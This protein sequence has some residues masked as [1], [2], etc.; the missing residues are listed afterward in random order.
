MV[1]LNKRGSEKGFA[2]GA[3]DVYLKRGNTDRQRSLDELDSLINFFLEKN[4]IS[5]DEVINLL[6]EKT[7]SESLVSMPLFYFR[8][9]AFS[10][11]QIIVFYLVEEKKMTIKEIGSLLHK[12]SS[13]VEKSYN[14][15]KL[16]NIKLCSFLSQEKNYIQ[17][18]L[19]IPLLIFS[20]PYLSPMES[21]IKYLKDDK[22]LKYNEI[23]RLLNRD[24]R[25]VWTA[26]HRAKYKVIFLLENPKKAIKANKK[27]VLA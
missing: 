27:E 3:A 18:S 22:K 6:K 14:E 25:T 5:Y 1:K 2:V 9:R 8:M 20:S 26:Y 24:A 15:A 19:M 17:N 21:L 16:I 10:P 7:S 4:S 23:A 13:V 11:L 12:R